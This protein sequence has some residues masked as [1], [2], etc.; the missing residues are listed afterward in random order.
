MKKTAKG[1]ISLDFLISA[2]SLILI[3]AGFIG[4]FQLSYNTTMQYNAKAEME[5][6]ISET[7]QVIN[8]A[9]MLE[10][11]T[12]KIYY[13]VKEITV[14]KEKKTVLRET[15]AVTINSNKI[16]FNAGEGENQITAEKEFYLPAGTTID[17]NSIT[18]KL[19]ISN[20]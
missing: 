4:I 17:Y 3:S 12:F 9:Q 10:G 7:V 18:K 1:Q 14:P 16:I 13:L 5:K 15:P 20:D 8:S 11:T 2:I 19:V 6:N